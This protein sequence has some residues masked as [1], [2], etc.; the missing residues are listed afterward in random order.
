MGFIPI[1]FISLVLSLIALVTVSKLLKLSTNILF[2]G[3]FGTIVGLLI[4]AL[5]SSSLSRLPGDFGVYLPTVVTVLSVFGTL[6]LFLSKKDLIL[7][8]FDGFSRVLKLVN[9]LN[10][11]QASSKEKKE[12]T[13][14]LLDTSVIIDGR[15][16]D[17]AETGFITSRLYVTRFVL[18]EL[19]NVAD[20]DNDMKRSRGRRGLETLN[21]QKKKLKIKIIDDDAEDIK[22][23]D[24]KLVSVARKKG[25][26]LMTTDY[27]LNK[28]AKIDGVEVLNVNELANSI[29]PIVIPGEDLKIKVVQVGK[30]RNQGVGYLTDGTMVVVENGDK[31]VGKEVNTEIKRILQTDAGKMF[32]AVPKKDK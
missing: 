19:Q 18:K 21:K 14:I 24:A 16:F 11:I 27:N 32:F 30:G 26:N 7:K 6:T 17:I 4:G 12:E 28:V 20:S 23:V 15:V 2:I 3:I 31:L 13:G 22:E 8:T 9:T 25:Y 29:K 5:A 10:P 1:V